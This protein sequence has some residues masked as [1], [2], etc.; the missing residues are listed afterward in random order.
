MVATNIPLRWSGKTEA[1]TVGTNIPLRW[2][3][4]TEADDRYK[5][6][7]ALEREDGGR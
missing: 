7:A 6:S 2:S 1:P 5:H 4:K 3:G